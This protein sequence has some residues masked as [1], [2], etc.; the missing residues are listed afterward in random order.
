[1]VFDFSAKLTGSVKRN[2]R[3]GNE[4]VFPWNEPFNHCARLVAFYCSYYLF[5]ELTCNKTAQI[6]L[7]YKAVKCIL[8]RRLAPGKFAINTDER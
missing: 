3:Q 7:C 4:T 8:D 1:M 6:Y 2:Q 5:K